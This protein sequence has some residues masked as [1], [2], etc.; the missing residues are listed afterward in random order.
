MDNRGQTIRLPSG[1]HVEYGEYGDPNGTPLLYFHGWP[2]SHHQA[3][4]I[5]A[6]AADRKIRVVAPNRPGIGRSSP[7]PGR[8]LADWPPLIREFADALGLRSWMVLGVS[9]GGPYALATAAELPSSTSAVGVACGAIPL[10]DFADHSGLLPAYRFLLALRKFA[11]WLLRPVFALGSAL[12][13]CPPHRFPMSLILRLVEPCD[14]VALRQKDVF[15]E[16]MVTYR[17]A[18]ASGMGAVIS[19]ADV[20]L[21]RWD[22]DLA[23]VRCPTY[24]WHGEQDRNIPIHMAKILAAK[25]PHAQC[26]WTADMGH[27]SLGLQKTGMFLDALLGHSPPGNLPLENP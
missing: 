16:V 20:Y 18:V 6:E 12:S 8:T 15:D 19:D 26:R 24:F 2:S 7:Q 22:I 17:E 3:F 1:A 14:R 11:P 25:I 4:S 13:H 23:H 21:E 5:D 9:G 27:Y 10:A